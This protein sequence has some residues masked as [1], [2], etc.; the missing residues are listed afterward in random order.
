MMSF[1]AALRREIPAQ[2]V[3]KSGSR[4]FF[5]RCGVSRRPEAV[6]HRR[7]RGTNGVVKGQDNH[8]PSFDCTPFRSFRSGTASFYSSPNTPNTKRLSQLPLH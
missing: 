5:G 7:A 6:S 1:R 2:L 8:K 3:A 4:G